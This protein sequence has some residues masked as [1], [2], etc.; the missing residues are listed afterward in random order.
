MSSAGKR[1]APFILAGACVSYASCVSYVACVHCVACVSYVACVG[2][3]PRFTIC[4]D[5][6]YLL[7][8][9]R[10]SNPLSWLRL[11]GLS[12]LVVHH[13][14]A[15]QAYIRHPQNLDLLVLSAQSTVYVYAYRLGP[16]TE[17]CI[18]KS[19]TTGIGTVSKNVAMSNSSIMM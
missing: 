6:L 12:N 8:T 13:K 9:D 14:S 17:F 7:Y 10:F 2:L 4:M 19:I 11:P 18:T 5:G 15:M 16:L 3:K 1:T